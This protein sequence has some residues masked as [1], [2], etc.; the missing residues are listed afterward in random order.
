MPGV[1]VIPGPGSVHSWTGIVRCSYDVSTGYGH[2]IFNSLYNSELN[3]I[4]E[5]TATLRRQK[6]VR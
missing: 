6:N 2:T 5:A 3:K 1:P 4:V